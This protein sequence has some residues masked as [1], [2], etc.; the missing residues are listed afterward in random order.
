MRNVLKIMILAGTLHSTLAWSEL[1]KP[2][3]RRADGGTVQ[4]ILLQ[5]P[6]WFSDSRRLD[7]MEWVRSEQAW[8]LTPQRKEEKK[9]NNKKKEE[10][11]QDKNN[12]KEN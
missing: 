10:H 2:L 9:K 11:E 6:Y 8:L 3:E 7:T 12:N 4:H 1:D 5:K